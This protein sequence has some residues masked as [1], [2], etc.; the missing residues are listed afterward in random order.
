MMT[1]TL[2]SPP[3]SLK[4]THHYLG[5]DTW[6]VA[7][8]DWYGIDTVLKSSD[9]FVLWPIG[10]QCLIYHWLDYAVNNDCKKIIFYASDRPA[11]TREVLKSAH[12][13]PIEW[14]LRSVARVDAQDCD[15]L[16]S[17]LPGM[18]FDQA[19]PKDGWSLLEH[20]FALQKHWLDVVLKGDDKM[21]VSL[22]LGRFCSI[23]PSVELKMPV[24]I[25]DYVTIGPDSVIGPYACINNGCVIEG[26]SEIDNAYV[27]EHTFLSGHTELRNGYIEGGRFINL[28]HRAKIDN[29]DALISTDLNFNNSQKSG[30][31]ERF[32]GLGLFLFFMVKAFFNKNSEFRT[33]K[34]F[35]EVSLKEAISGTLGFRRKH[36]FWQVFKGNLKLIGVLPRTHFHLENLDP[37]WADILKTVPCG[38]ISYA[39]LEHCHSL[40]EEMESVHAVYQATHD[41]KLMRKMILAS[42]WKLLHTEPVDE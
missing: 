4:S 35:K 19:L 36:W 27:G 38:V 18:T 33:W 3:S 37:E 2:Q 5:A 10:D 7:L 32:I 26:P 31:I 15:V 29:M 34:T 8:P 20:W 28:S 13:W 22:S 24:W 42:Y 40:E 14:E 25:G 17:H 11:H 6:K 1:T 12:L 16:A 39:D 41:P 21:L 9:P 30:Y 23:H